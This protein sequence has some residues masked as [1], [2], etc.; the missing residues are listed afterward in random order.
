MPQ[1]K[2]MVDRFCKDEKKKNQENQYECCNKQRGQEQYLCFSTA[3]PNPQYM[4][5]DVHSGDHASLDMFCGTYKT[6]QKM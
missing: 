6:L 4:N 3:A 1:W 2:K 5:D